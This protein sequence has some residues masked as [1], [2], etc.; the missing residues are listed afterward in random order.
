MRK[1]MSDVRERQKVNDADTGE[2]RE[3]F[4]RLR[5]RRISSRVP[6]NENGILCS[7]KAANELIDDLRVRAARHVGAVAI[8]GER[9]H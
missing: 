9:A 7:E 5:G 8:G 6:R 1:C 4:D 2:G 3:L